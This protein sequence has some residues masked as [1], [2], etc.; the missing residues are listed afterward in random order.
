MTTLQ[1][2]KAEALQG[3]SS[4]GLLARK[5][6]GEN[7]N[8]G[9]WVLETVLFAAIQPLKVM[10]VSV[11]LWLHRQ[12]HANTCVPTRSGLPQPGWA[13]LFLSVSFA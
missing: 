1:S 7:L 13:W 11:P 10:L 2:K 8:P 5:R 6:Q 4:Q 9:S 12:T 3:S